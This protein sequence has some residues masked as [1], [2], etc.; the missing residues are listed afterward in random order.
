MA[1]RTIVSLDSTI[2]GAQTKGV[3]KS[4]GPIDASSSKFIEVTVN[5]N[6]DN[7]YGGSVQFTDGS[8]TITSRPLSAKRVNKVYLASVPT[9]TDSNVMRMYGDAGTALESMNVSNITV[10]LVSARDASSSICS[11]FNVEY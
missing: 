4:V 10:K 7:R 6:F 9:L 5:A 2:T 1:S 8:K 3:I 11:L